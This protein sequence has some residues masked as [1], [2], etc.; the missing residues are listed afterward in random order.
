MI[1]Q[2]IT[3]H[4][5]T[6]FYAFGEGVHGNNTS[7]KNIRMDNQRELFK[8]MDTCF[9]TYLVPTYFQARVTKQHPFLH[10]F[11]IEG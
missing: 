10:C 6:L 4:G 9:S 7:L 2:K 11:C 8:V 5:W 1:H 3:P